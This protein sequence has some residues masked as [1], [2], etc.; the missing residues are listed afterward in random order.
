MQ[1]DGERGEL[2]IRL[3]WEMCAVPPIWGIS[4]MREGYPIVMAGI[5]KSEGK[6]RKRREILGTVGKGFKTR[7]GGEEGGECEVGRGI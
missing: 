2:D 7:V 5:G 4:P 1:V 6:R 3:N